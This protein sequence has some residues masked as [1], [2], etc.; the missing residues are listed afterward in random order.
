MWD[1]IDHSSEVRI[2]IRDD[3]SFEWSCFWHENNKYFEREGKGKNILQ[4]DITE[5]IKYLKIIRNKI[6][7]NT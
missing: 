4:E 3:F 2:K 6:N 7:A 1:T 5:F